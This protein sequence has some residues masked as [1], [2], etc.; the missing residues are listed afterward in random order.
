MS[1]TGQLS[2]IQ[3]PFEK[4]KQAYA[5]IREISSTQH[6]EQSYAEIIRS[7]AKKT[8]IPIRVVTEPRPKK[9][10]YSPSQRESDESKVGENEAK[11]FK[12]RFHK[13]DRHDWKDCDEA[14]ANAYCYI[15]RKKGHPT[16]KHPKRGDGNGEDGRAAETGNDE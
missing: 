6:N 4:L 9:T 1:E 16:F 10:A 15:C 2:T 11:T 8:T 14:L 12:C 7:K 5:L 3:N 13:T